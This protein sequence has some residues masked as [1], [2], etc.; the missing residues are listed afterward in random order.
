MMKKRVY[1]VLIIWVTLLMLSISASAV[2]EEGAVEFGNTI[3]PISG[4]EIIEDEV[5]KYE[6]NGVIY[7]LC[8]TMCLKDFKKDP[9]KYIEKLEAQKEVEEEAEEHGHTDEHPH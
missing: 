1:T 6:Y 9:E 3:C 2:A 7:N 5:V 4:E 8:C